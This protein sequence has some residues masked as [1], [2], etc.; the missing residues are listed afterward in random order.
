MTEI[1]A[2]EMELKKRSILFEQSGI[3][4]HCG[5]RITPGEPFNISH[6]IAKHKWR[7]QKYGSEVINHRFNLVA[8]HPGNCNDGVMLNIQKNEG[9]ALLRAIFLDLDYEIP[10]DLKEQSNE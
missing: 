6:R 1:E 7:L 10:E 4:G 5:K 3:C 8:T 2:Y 9:K